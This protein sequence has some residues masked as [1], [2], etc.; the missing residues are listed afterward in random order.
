MAIDVV[1]DPPSRMDDPETFSTK[2]D[3]TMA[4]LNSW[5]TQAN[6]LA[7]SVNGD[8]ESSGQSASEALNSK[9]A[10]AQGAAEALASANAAAV[11][12]GAGRWV[13]GQAYAEGA[14]A[15]SPLNYQ[16]YRRKSAGSSATD[17]SLDVANWS[18]LVV[19]DP[20]AVKTGGGQLLPNQIN[21]L[22]DSGTYTLP[23]AVSVPADTRIDVEITDLYR[24]QTPL[25]QAGAD[26]EI[27]WS[28]G[29][30]TEFL[31]DAQQSMSVRFISD[32]VSSWRM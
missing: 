21:E 10:A 31:F 28:G 25:V 20:V 4:K 17:P 7:E 5:S 32:G 1:F 30:D 6:A 14:C 26:D 15:W 23:A 8:K 3:D 29:T 13:S 9:N 24:M 12:A 19:A 27:V 18:L 22:Q 16:T 11:A 2:A